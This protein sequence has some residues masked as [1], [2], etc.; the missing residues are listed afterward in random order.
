MTIT[1]P[2]RD[3]HAGL[4][5]HVAALAEAGDAVGRAPLEALRTLVDDSYRFLDEHLIPHARTEERFLYPAVNRAVGAAEMTATMERDHVEVIA[6]TERLSE[7]RARLAEAG[8][9][10]DD[11]ALALRRVLYGLHA[12]VKVHFAK[13]EEVYLP[14]LDDRLSA[15]DAHELFEAMHGAEHA[16]HH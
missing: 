2:L 8:E 9:L 11:L 10:D 16:H 1:Q 6:L 12:L 14:I 15:H 3:E 4:Y 5:P 7:L 13:E